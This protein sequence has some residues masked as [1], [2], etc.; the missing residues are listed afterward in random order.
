MSSPRTTPLRRATSEILAR[1]HPRRTIDANRKVVM[2]GL[3]DA[4]W[5]AFMAATPQLV[6]MTADPNYLQLLAARQAEATLL[7]A[8]A[9]SPPLVADSLNADDARSSHA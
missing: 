7:V 8:A 1:F 9:E 6:L 3:I 4:H 2:P 5:H